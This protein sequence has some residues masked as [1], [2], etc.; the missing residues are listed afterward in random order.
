[1][2]LKESNKNKFSSQK[3]ELDSFEMFNLQEQ[4]EF[5]NMCDYYGLPAFDG[6]FPISIWES[7]FLIDIRRRM[8]SGSEL[9]HGQLQTL[10]KIC[11]GTPITSRQETYLK[12]L[13]YEEDTSTLTKR[14]ASR[15]I[16]NK[17]TYGTFEGESE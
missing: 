12:S 4:Q 2:Q 3:I 7:N 11:D 10:K 6:S 1:M 9:T 16:Y 15:L 17:N 14:L 5:K 8:A 13:G